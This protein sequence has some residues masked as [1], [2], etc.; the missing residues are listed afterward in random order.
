MPVS[1]FDRW[2]LLGWPFFGNF[3]YLLRKR[4]KKKKDV[5][6]GDIF[7][8]NEE[9]ENYPTRESIKRIGN[10]KWYVKFTINSKS[11]SL[12]IYPRI[13]GNSWPY[14]EKSLLLSVYPIQKP[15][16]PGGKFPTLSLPLRILYILAVFPFYFS[17][18]PFF[19]P[20]LFSISSP[21][22]NLN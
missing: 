6:Y 8:E 9:E 17:Q 21:F 18:N 3:K 22:F 5:W 2:I 15:P 16:K 7:K 4:K 20:L 1:I 11:R 14:L 10:D 19:S 12:S 13:S